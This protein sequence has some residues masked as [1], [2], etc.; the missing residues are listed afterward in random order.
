MA[1]CTLS[2]GFASDVAMVAPHSSLAHE[3]PFSMIQSYSCSFTVVHDHSHF[4]SSF[5]SAFLFTVIPCLVYLFLKL[6]ICLECRNCSSLLLNACLECC[7][8]LL[9]I[10]SVCLEC[11]NFLSLLL[12]VHLGCRDGLH[13]DGVPYV[14]PSVKSWPSHPRD[15]VELGRGSR[16][17][18]AA[19]PE[20]ELL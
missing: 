9:L 12:N 11:R 10:V 20:L 5:A 13:L 3:D 8:C 14:L 4:Y 7:N 19:I 1:S 18:R 15:S 6:H 16:T 17:P 2:V